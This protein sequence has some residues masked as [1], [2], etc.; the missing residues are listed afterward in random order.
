MKLVKMMNGME[1]EI[2]LFCSFHNFSFKAISEFK[3]SY[4]ITEF[5]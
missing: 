1:K 4:K 2:L 3:I 5:Y